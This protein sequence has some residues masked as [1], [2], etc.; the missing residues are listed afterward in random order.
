MDLASALSGLS[1]LLA[2]ANGRSG[3]Y[4]QHSV[5]WSL[6]CLNFSKAKGMMN[7]IPN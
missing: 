3:E 5:A 7:V 1:K 2:V 6:E 4:Y